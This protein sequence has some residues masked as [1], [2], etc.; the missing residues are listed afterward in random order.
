MSVQ[1][2]GEA[3]FFMKQPREASIEAQMGTVRQRKASRHCWK[4]KA[5]LHKLLQA[6]GLTSGACPFL[7]C[8]G[9]Q[10]CLALS[11]VTLGHHC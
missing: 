11:R 10:L 2:P 3:Q 8:S 4:T 6:P 5:K 7:R 1:R 9:T